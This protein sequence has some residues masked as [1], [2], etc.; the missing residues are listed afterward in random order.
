MVSQ[1]KV[2]SFGDIEMA[3]D[4]TYYQ[5]FEFLGLSLTIKTTK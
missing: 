5:I 4:A 2:D 3:C 1:C